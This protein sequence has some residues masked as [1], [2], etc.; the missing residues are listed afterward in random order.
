MK[1]SVVKL[2]FALEL[3]NK[4]WALS[5]T[6]TDS[7]NAVCENLQKTFLASSR[8]GLGYRRRERRKSGSRKPAGIS[9]RHA[10]R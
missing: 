9:H 3:K 5:K 8:D 1:D 10:G 4:F 2:Q 7:I 6:W